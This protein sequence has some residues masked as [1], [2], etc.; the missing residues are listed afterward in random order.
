MKKKI[1]KDKV[2]PYKISAII[3]TEE[4]L[5]ELLQSGQE[6]GKEDE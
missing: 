6:G 4:E 3:Y 2:E 1:K 5:E